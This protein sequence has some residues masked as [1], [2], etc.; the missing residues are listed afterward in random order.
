MQTKHTET[1]WL[2]CSEVCLFSVCSP[3]LSKSPVKGI[4]LRLQVLPLNAI[5]QTVP[6]ILGGERVIHFRAMHSCSTSKMSSSAQCGAVSYRRVS[7]PTC[8]V[9]IS[10]ETSPIGGIAWSIVSCQRQP[11]LSPLRRPQPTQ[12]LLLQGI[13]GCI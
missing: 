9:L 3:S 12:L 8:T 7:S 10:A 6:V 11:Q 1:G 2:N 5:L 4:I 13:N